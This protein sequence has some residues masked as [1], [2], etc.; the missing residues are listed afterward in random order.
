MLK[1]DRTLLLGGALLLSTFAF[2]CSQTP[3]PAESTPV[4]AATPRPLR[5]NVLTA[6][7]QNALTPDAILASLKEGNQR[8][9]KGDLTIRD[10]TAMVRKAAAGQF[11]KAVVLSCLDSRIPVED[12][13]DKGIGDMFIARVAG[14]IVNPDILGSMEFGTKVAGAKVILVLGHNDCGA[15]KGAIDDVKL[16]NLTAL[17]ARMRPAVTASAS[18]AGEKTS[19]NYAYVD[20]VSEANVLAVIKDIRAKSPILAEMEK[21]GG[22]KIVGA[23]Y[24]L[25]SGE[26]KFL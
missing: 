9:A 14:N 26:V 24:D 23:Y 8:F 7:Q 5:E 12:V 25:E 10:H 4:A 15:V 11:P 2:G 22:L 6:E 18:F 19:K 20:A 16:G 1:N 13:F 3:A 17:L 21:S